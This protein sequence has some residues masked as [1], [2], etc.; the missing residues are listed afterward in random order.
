MP[1]AAPATAA[2]H[3]QAQWTSRTVPKNGTWIVN[4]ASISHPSEYPAVAQSREFQCRS[5]TARQAPAAT[6]APCFKNSITFLQNVRCFGSGIDATF[7]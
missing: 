1:W 5:Y 3:F 7:R 6:E 2:I 4:S